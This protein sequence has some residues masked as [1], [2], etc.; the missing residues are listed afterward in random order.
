MPVP[1]IYFLRHGETEWNALGRLQGTQDIPL[2]ARGRSQAAH[3]ADVLAGLFRRDGKDKAALPYVSSP[4]GRARQT[5]ELVRRKLELPLADYSLDDRLREIG[6]G[7]WE[8]LTLAESEASDPDVYARRLA[9]KW[10][11]APAGGETYAAVQLRVLDWYESLL[12]DTVAVAHGGTC[13]ALMVALGIE[14]PASAADLYIQQ[15][16]VYVFRDGRLEK[17]S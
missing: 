12:V 1:T 10:T 16:A 17:F 13:R 8:G 11:V 2:N 3:A 5:M 9:D 7:T 4:L 6:Y 15:G 14:T